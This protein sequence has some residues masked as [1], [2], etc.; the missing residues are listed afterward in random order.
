[1]NLYIAIFV[2]AAL[3][4]AVVTDLKDQRIPN[5]LT[6]TLAVAGIA[7][8]VMAS[9]LDGLGFSL[10]G[11]AIGLGVMLPPYLMGVMGGGDVKLMAA[12]GAC[13]G[14]GDTVAAFLFTSLAGG[15]YALVVL[16]FRRGV[17]SRVLKNF[18]TTLWVMSATGE[19]GEYAPAT[20]GERLP[21]L[22]YGLAIAAGTVAALARHAVISGIAA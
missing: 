10:I 11:L 17:L 16:A 4:I 2:L 9:G 13:L 15:L 19:R 18:W 22:C 14:A 8:H 5:W 3:T 7:Y 1:M 20:K 12:V 6:L 21:R